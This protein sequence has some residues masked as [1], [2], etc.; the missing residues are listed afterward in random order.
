MMIAGP[1][2]QWDERQTACPAGFTP[3]SSSIRKSLAARKGDTDTCI[4]VFMFC[5]RAKEDLLVFTSNEDH[6]NSP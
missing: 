2:A 3:T 1:A 4:H 6:L 5:Q